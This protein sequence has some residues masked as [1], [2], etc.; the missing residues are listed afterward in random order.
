MYK[1][2]ITFLDAILSPHDYPQLDSPDGNWNWDS[3][4]RVKAQRLKASL[5]SFQTLAVLLIT[6][7]VLDEV[8]SLAAKL[9]KWDQDI[10]EAYRMVDAVIDRVKVHCTIDT[11]FSSWYD[12]I[13]ELTEKISAT[14]SIPRKTSIQ[15]NHSN[16][17]SASP[18]EHYIVAIPL[19]Y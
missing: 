14:E 16:T 9:Q 18:Q 1:A 4:T 5:S 6:K 2:L 12:E 19:I 17:P 10:Y 8:K 11:T 15:R 3:D 7:N 13:L